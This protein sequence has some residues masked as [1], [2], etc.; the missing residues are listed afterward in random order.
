VASLFYDSSLRLIEALRLRIKD[1]DLEK[2]E[3]VVR[4][5][6]GDKVRRTVLPGKSQS[7]LDTQIQRVTVLHEQDLHNGL[8][9][10]YLPQALGCKFPHA[11]RESPN[12]Q[13]SV[14]R[15]TVCNLL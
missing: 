9:P 8:D 12:N 7:S 2:Q 14:G 6:K 13:T 3:I 10:V 11:G 15:Q 1:C 5:G 4:S